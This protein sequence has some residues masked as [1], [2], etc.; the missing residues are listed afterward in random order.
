MASSNPAT[1]SDGAET[2]P[3]KVTL[4]GPEETLLATLYGRAQDAASDNPV[5]A[6][7]WASE[8]IDKI[9]YDFSK[10]GMDATACTTVAIRAQALDNWTSNFLATHSSATV[11]HLGAGLDSRCFRIQHGAGVRWVDLDLPDA[12]ALR[13]RLVPSPEGDY[14]LLSTSVADHDQWLPNIPA[15]RPT[16]VVLEGLTMYLH[17]EEGKRLLQSIVSRFAARVYE[18]SSKHRVGV[19]LGNR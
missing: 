10:T 7:R 1:L 6:D 18:A 5:L 9:D 16:I 3:T 15:D 8:V 2:R 17:E 13:R 4:T 14:T 11:L 19:A 12:V